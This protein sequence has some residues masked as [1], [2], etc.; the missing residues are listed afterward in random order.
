MRGKKYLAL[1]FVPPEKHT[2][3]NFTAVY[4]VG[5]LKKHMAEA[6]GFCGVLLAQG[7]GK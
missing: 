6:F 1:R 3:Y 4:D 7:G 5:N 2:R